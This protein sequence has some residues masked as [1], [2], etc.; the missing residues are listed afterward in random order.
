MLEFWLMS[1]N[2]S[3][4]DKMFCNDKSSSS[5]I[6]YKLF[7]KAASQYV[8]KLLPYLVLPG[9]VEIDESRVGRKAY[10]M[11]GGFPKC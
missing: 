6:Y 7:R 11:K 2:G 9:P 8:K 10:T 4:P 5:V 3:V 1:S